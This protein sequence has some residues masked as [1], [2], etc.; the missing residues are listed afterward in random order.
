MTPGM[1]PT[2]RYLDLLKSTLLDDIYIENE[3]RLMYLFAMHATQSKPDFEVVR[4][5]GRHLPDL[6]AK[7]REARLDG[8]AWWHWKSASGGRQRVIDLRNGCMFSHTMIGRKRLENIE[9]CLDAIRT[10]GIAGD[11]IETG[12]WRGGATIFMRGY[13]AAHDMPE[14][15]V[16]VADSFEGL[17]RPSLAQDEGWDF[18]P[19]Q[20]PILAVS[21]E[22]VQENF[23]RYDL[24]DDRVRFLKGWFRDTLPA[25]PIGKLALA[26]L[27]GDLYES[28]M[29]ALN[30]LYERVVP[31]GFLIIDDY[32]DFEPCQRA[33]DEF[34]R[35]H[36]IAAPLERIDWAGAYWRK[37]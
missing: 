28:T 18:S 12:V 3:V 19:A 11:L 8:R 23:R 35:D 16:W 2:R 37:P 30:A 32:G 33:V 9:H 7:A 34:R 22:E 13:L 6:L 10:D 24:L 14:R 17:P 36:G 27:D 20:M 26:R 25:A 5:I 29:D 15:I 21:L 4:Q 1:N 31:G